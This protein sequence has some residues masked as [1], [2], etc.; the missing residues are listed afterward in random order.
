MPLRVKW[1]IVIVDRTVGEM[2]RPRLRARQR[3]AVGTARR[4]AA[5]HRV[6]DFRVELQRVGR[7]AGPECLHRKG[8]AAFG[9]QRRAGRQVE[10]LAMPLVDMV[11]PG[12]VRGTPLHRRMDRVVADLGMLID[13]AEHAGAEIA[14]EHLRTEADAEQRL[15]LAQRHAHPLDLTADEGIFVVGAVRAAEHDS[16]GVLFQR[17]GQRVVEARPTNIERIAHSREEVPHP[18]GRR[19][20]LMENNENGKLRTLPARLACQRKSPPDGRILGLRSLRMPLHATFMQAPQCLQV[21]RAAK[22]AAA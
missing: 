8:L 13:V 16:A 18:T 22:K 1:R 2:R 11:R 5:G 7:G 15:L 3:H 6:S 19:M 10:P 21:D 4:P 9:E 14:R 17:R 12:I 20:F